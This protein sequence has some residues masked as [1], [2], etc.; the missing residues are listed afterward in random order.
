MEYEIR[1]YYDPMY[2][3]KPEQVSELYTRFNLTG[4]NINCLEY[5]S[6]CMDQKLRRIIQGQINDFMLGETKSLPPLAFAHFEKLDQKQA[7]SLV[8]TI[9]NEFKIKKIEITNTN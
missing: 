4:E 6:K 9:T 1:F 5:S 3:V 8:D 7:L 2:E